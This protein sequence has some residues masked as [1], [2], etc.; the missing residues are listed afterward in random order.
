M[1]PEMSYRLAQLHHEE[2]IADARRSPSRGARRARRAARV[3]RGFFQRCHDTHV[4]TVFQP[5]PIV[6]LPP[7][8]EGLGATG[9]RH[10]A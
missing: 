1:H 3:G 9:V 2:L 4:P 7:P 8:R 5:S 6:P 10:V